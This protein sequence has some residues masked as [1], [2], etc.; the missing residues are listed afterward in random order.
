MIRSRVRCGVRIWLYY[1]THEHDTIF[2]YMKKESI[3]IK[4]IETV[5]AYVPIF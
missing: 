1:F 2:I 4:E 3:V 5:G